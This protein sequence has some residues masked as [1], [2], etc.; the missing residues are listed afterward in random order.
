MSR[1]IQQGISLA[2]A[3]YPSSVSMWWTVSAFLG[4]FAI[5][6]KV[7]QKRGNKNNVR[8]NTE[9]IMWFK[10]GKYSTKKQSSSPKN[11]PHEQANKGWWGRRTTIKNAARTQI[12]T[13]R[14]RKFEQCTGQ[15]QLAHK[16]TEYALTDA[17]NQRNFRHRWDFVCESC[18]VDSEF[19]LQTAN[20]CQIFN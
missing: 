4:A 11:G 1:W 13:A 12:C 8:C 16:F 3:A 19:H 10:S 14:H 17:A 2:A 5:A 18:A 7:A 20:F 9:W 15:P 6:A